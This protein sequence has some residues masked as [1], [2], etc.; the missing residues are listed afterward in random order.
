ME[1]VILYTSYDPISGNMELNSWDYV[2]LSAQ[3]IQIQKHIWFPICLYQEGTYLLRS[4]N[5]ENHEYKLIHLRW[6]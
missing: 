2:F 6:I 5:M 4:L 1:S 3:N